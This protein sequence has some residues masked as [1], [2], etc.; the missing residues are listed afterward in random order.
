MELD[1][2]DRAWNT[3]QYGDAFGIRIWNSWSDQWGQNG[4]GVLTEGKATNNGA[5]ALVSMEAD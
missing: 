2:F 5:I 1:E 4:M 3:P